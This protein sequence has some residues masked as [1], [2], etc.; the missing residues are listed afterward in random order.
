MKSVIYRAAC[1]VPGWSGTFDSLEQAI[2]FC[3]VDAFFKDNSKA[4]VEEI[5]TE[6]SFVQNV[7]VESVSKAIVWESK[8]EKTD[9]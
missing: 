5:T 7:P 9:D 2:E 4:M 8:L 1:G 6:Y 3:K